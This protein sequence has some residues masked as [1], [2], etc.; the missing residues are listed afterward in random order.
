MAESERLLIMATCDTK[1]DTRPHDWFRVK[2]GGGVI[3]VCAL[4]R[5]DIER[6]VLEAMD[7]PFGGS[8]FSDTFGLTAEPGS[9]TD[10]HIVDASDKTASLWHNTSQATGGRV[11]FLGNVVETLY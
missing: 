8:N 6:T 7:S 5:L 3:A 1:P 2:V 11:I 9:I 4:S 10:D